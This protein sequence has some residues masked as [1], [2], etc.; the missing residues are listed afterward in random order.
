MLQYIHGCLYIL[1]IDP[2]SV[3]SAESGLSRADGAVQRLR[4]CGACY[5]PERYHLHPVLAVHLGILC[6]SFPEDKQ[7]D[8]RAIL[9][10]CA[11]T[12]GA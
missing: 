4:V 1:A 10:L 9:G 5:R 8:A 3:C 7:D 12:R 6:S 2:R 11:G